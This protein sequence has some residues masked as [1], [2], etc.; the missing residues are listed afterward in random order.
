MVSFQDVMYYGLEW[1][2]DERRWTRIILYFIRL[3]W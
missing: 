1:N 2:A 3:L